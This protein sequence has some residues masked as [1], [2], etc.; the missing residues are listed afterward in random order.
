MDRLPEFD[1]G[2]VAFFCKGLSLLSVVYEP[3][4]IIADI[5][6]DWYYV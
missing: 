4:F 5:G 3:I 1:K 6:S 2:M